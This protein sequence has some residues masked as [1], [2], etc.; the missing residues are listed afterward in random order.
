MKQDDDDEA[1]TEDAVSW[2]ARLERDDADWAGYT[3][4]LEAD[5]R[6]RAAYNRI[7]LVEAVVDDHREEVGRL[8]R[9]APPA[10]ARQGW[11]GR[12]TPRTMGFV[13]TGIAAAAALFFAM[14]IMWT[15]GSTQSYEAGAG[16][17]QLIVLAD[18]VRVTLSPASRIVVRGKDAQHI[19]L[20]RGEAFF[21][22]RHDP[23]RTLI[24]SAGDY[25]IADI[26]TRFSVNI[27]GDALRVGVSEGT[28]TVSSDSTRAVDVT[29]GR[30]LVSTDDRLIL[31][32]VAL[33]DVA[34][35]RSGRLS[36]SDAP[37]SM[38]AADISRYSGRRIVIDPALEKAH[39]SGSLAIGD[40]S[41]L[42][43]D[44]AAVMGTSVRREG[45]RDYIGGGAR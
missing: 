28:V 45:E 29:A 18:D 17:E 8:L 42:L 14:P 2:Q 27:A 39:F 22:V 43:Q 23:A 30:Q 41:R 9:P 32:S 1:V 11:F 13:G 6:H 21:D 7:A 3:R 12:V 44:L 33:T 4:W 40:S 15:S 25:S 26:G 5:P 31:S 20:T 19:E 24:V 36:Y 16:A 38:V 34:S 35:W 10:P 37:L